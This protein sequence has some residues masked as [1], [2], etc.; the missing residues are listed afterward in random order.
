MEQQIF[1]PG[2]IVEILDCIDL[3][4][5]TIATVKGIEQDDEFEGLF[6]LYLVANNHAL[7]DKYEEKIGYYW[8]IIENISPYITLL[9]RATD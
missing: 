6:F 2:D 9:S 3:E 8:D 5:K 7:N 4:S 1:M